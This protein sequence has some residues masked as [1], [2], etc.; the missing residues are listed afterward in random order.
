MHR[1][2]S[3]CPKT[4]FPLL[5]PSNQPNKPDL[6]A[7][8]AQMDRASACGAGGHKFESCRV[9]HRFAP[10]NPCPF[11]MKILVKIIHYLFGI[12]VIGLSLAV[13]Y[14]TFI[15]LEKAGIGSL[16]QLFNWL[17]APLTI[18]SAIT[19]V[20]FWLICLHLSWQFFKSLRDP[21]G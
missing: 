21:R 14:I 16:D 17:S 10:A 2:L 1:T 19:S 15:T 3:T 9:H 8:V 18:F 12:I 6:H 11:P 4:P 5:F 13:P 20:I 7:L